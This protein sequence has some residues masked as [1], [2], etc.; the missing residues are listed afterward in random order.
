MYKM[1]VEMHIIF[2]YMSPKNETTD[3]DITLLS[4]DF[5]QDHLLTSNKVRSALS[6]RDQFKGILRISVSQGL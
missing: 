6:T 2:V 3:I 4:S 1:R 5:N